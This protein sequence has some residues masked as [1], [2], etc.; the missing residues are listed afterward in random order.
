MTV[1]RIAFCMALCVVSGPAHAQEL[2][3]VREIGSATGSEEYTFNRVGGM[4]IATDGTTFVV[5]AGDQLVKVYSAR[6]AFLRSFGR[7]GSGPGEFMLPGRIVLSGDTVIV[8]DVRQSRVSRFNR[9][10]DHISTEPLPAPAGLALSDV[11]PLRHGQAIGASIFRASLGNDASHDP[12][13]RIILFRGRSGTTDTLAT[14]QGE[15][16]I[17]YDADQQALWSVTSTPFGVGGAYALH[18][19]SLIALI[20]G[21]AGSVSWLTVGP[22]H[23]DTLRTADLGVRGT[24]I[25]AR[26]RR[27]VEDSLRARRANL[28]S[29]LGFVFPPTYSA[30]TGTALFDDRTQLWI[31]LNNDDAA[32]ASW[33]RIDS[34][35]TSRRIGVPK[36]FTIRAIVGDM[37]YGVWT[38]E[39]D[40]QT[41][42]VY[43]LVR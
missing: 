14:F 10:G 5:D 30:V 3:L 15:A 27:L 9:E 7:Q 22:S 29:R 6:G 42:R 26:H 12:N 17:W 19:D 28:P 34:S 4:A 25:T 2:R 8:F 1:L 39:L 35:G 24:P 36:Q 33:L 13:I 20:D 41:V 38:G 11:R 37:I 16:A 31:E 18:G 43:E 23:L 40:V 21:V 32:Q